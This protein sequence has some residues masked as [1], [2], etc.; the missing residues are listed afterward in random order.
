MRKK[1]DLRCWVAVALSIAAV[2]MLFVVTFTQIEDK[3]K[4]NT[5]SYVTFSEMFKEGGGS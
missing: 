4:L 5:N 1:C 2:I 3:R